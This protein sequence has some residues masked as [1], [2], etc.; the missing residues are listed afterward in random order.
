[1]VHNK[2]PQP[3]T[4]TT[5]P[6][7]TTQA[8]AGA[9][10][11]SSSCLDGSITRVGPGLNPQYTHAWYAREA[12]GCSLNSTQP[13]HLFR[14]FF[15]FLFFF[16]LF[17]TFSFFSLSFFFCL[18]FSFF[19]CLVFSLFFSLSLFFFLFLFFFLS[20]SLSFLFSFFFFRLSFFSFSFFFSFSLFC[21]DP[22]PSPEDRFICS[23][24]CFC[25]RLDWVLAPIRR[26]VRVSNH[27]KFVVL[28]VHA[29][30]THAWFAAAFRL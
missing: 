2:L 1:M 6:R 29:Q 15:F 17:F 23:Q 26:I 18:F 13:M 21:F 19:F 9:L 27:T 22:I 16:S 12:V 20:F 28:F 5:I 11:F 14:F 10:M 30:F 24:F 25:F 8:R 3:D 7:A 4:T